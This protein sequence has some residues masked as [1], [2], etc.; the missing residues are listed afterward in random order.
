MVVVT[1][2]LQSSIM[3]TDNSL[4]L[5]DRLPSAVGVMCDGYNVICAHAHTLNH[6]LL[7]TVTSIQ[8]H[9]YIAHVCKPC[10]Y[11]HN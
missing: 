7:H 9:K 2:P 11:T 4:S 5:S 1:L 8:H 10:A 3:A 6:L